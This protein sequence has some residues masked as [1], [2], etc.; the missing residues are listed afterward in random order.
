[1]LNEM[2]RRG[3]MDALEKFAAT[4]VHTLVSALS[5]L[6]PNAGAMVAGMTAPDG[7]VLGHLFRTGVGAHGGK[8]LGTGFGQSV[9]GLIAMLLK[10]NP[11]ALR[12]IGGQLGG[13]AGG[14]TGGHVGHNWAQQAS[15]S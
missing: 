9:G 12:E 2:Y 5:A 6:D 3:Q 15:Y 1:M 13:M 7:G 14:A 10:Q 8:A 4:D 11:K